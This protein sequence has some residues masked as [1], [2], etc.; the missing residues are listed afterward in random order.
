MRFWFMT[1][2]NFEGRSKVYELKAI[3]NFNKATG[4]SQIDMGHK[5][6]VI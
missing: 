2:C 3:W 4:L 1:P 6:P 5:R